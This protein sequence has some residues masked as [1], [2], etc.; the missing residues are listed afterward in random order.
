MKDE[1]CYFRYL[2]E[3][4]SKEDLISQIV[5]QISNYTYVLNKDELIMT[6]SPSS[7]NLKA[8]ELSKTLSSIA[9]KAQTFIC[10]SLQMTVL[11]QQSMP[12]VPVSLDSIRGKSVSCTGLDELKES[13]KNDKGSQLRTASLK[14]SMLKQWNSE[15]AQ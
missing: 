3:T 12:R 4:P 10:K 14:A 9:V 5:R 6:V 15:N 13:N 7:I 11:G 8:P 1:M 2:D